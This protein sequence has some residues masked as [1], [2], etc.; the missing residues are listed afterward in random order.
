MAE[1]LDDD[2]EEEAR[3]PSRKRRL[4]CTST[5]AIVGL[6]GAGGETDAVKST[7]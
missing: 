1:A 5:L 6:G 4:G 7:G 2:A 3:L